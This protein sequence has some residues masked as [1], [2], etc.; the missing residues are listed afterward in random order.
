MLDD[1]YWQLAPL[2]QQGLRCCI[3]TQ[4]TDVEEERN[5]LLTWDRR[6]LKADADRLRELNTAWKAAAD[7]GKE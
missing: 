5:G 3:Y 2:K 7:T 1:L 4:L 6:Q